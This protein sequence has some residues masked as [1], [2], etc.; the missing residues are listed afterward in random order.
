MYIYLGN[1]INILSDFDPCSHRKVNG[2]VVRYNSVNFG[3]TVWNQY[4]KVSAYYVVIHKNI[5]KIYI[6]IYWFHVWN[7]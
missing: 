4:V 3:K 2:K 7:S 5:V 6:Q 1:Y